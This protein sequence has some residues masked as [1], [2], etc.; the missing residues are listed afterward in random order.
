[1]M[2]EFKYPKQSDRHDG[3]NDKCSFNNERD[4]LISDKAQKLLHGIVSNRAALVRPSDK[5]RTNV[6]ATREQGLKN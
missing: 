3:R 4:G 5:H 6:R 1:M 2:H